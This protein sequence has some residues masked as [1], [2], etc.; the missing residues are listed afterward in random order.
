MLDLE[1]PPLLRFHFHLLS[2]ESL[3]FTLTEPHSISDGWSTH[4]TLMEIFEHFQAAMQGSKPRQLPP[5]R[6]SYRDFIAKE[7]QTLES[8]SAKAYWEDRL[9]GA[10]PS[11]L[12]RWPG[13]TKIDVTGHQLHRTREDR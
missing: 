3:Q 4:L 11:L 2:D 12:P 5:L 7:I 10:Q 6:S 1:K 13:R 9:K 8:E